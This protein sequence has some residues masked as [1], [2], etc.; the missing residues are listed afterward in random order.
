[1]IE[2]GEGPPLDDRLAHGP[3]PVHEALSIGG[4]IVD[5][6]AAAHEWGIVHRDLKQSNIEVSQTAR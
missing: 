1:V 2:L 4:P 5:A 3:L 6:L